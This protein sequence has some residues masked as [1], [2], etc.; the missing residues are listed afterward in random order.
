MLFRSARPETPVNDTGDT[1]KHGD[2]FSGLKKLF[3]RA[4]APET[5]TAAASETQVTPAST[6]TSPTASENTAEDKALATT[7]VPTPEPVVAPTTTATAP[8]ASQNSPAP[9][10]ERAPASPSIREMTADFHKIMGDNQGRKNGENESGDVI[11]HAEGTAPATQHLTDHPEE[12]PVPRA[13]SQPDT[14]PPVGKSPAEPQPTAKSESAATNPVPRTTETSATSDTTDKPGRLRGFFGK[15][16]G[17]KQNDTST[18]PTLSTP[19]QEN[20]VTAAPATVATDHVQEQKQAAAEESRQA[21]EPVTATEKPV[22]VARAEPE[23]QNP[24]LAETAAKKLQATPLETLTAR[25]VEGDAEAQYQ[26]GKT[27]YLGDQGTPDYGQAFIWYRRAALQGHAEAQYNLGTMYL[28]GE[29]IA[30]S[31]TEAKDWYARAADQGHEA[32]RHN[33]ENL[34]QIT[35]KQETPAP[36]TEVAAVE[37]KAE[38]KKG[39]VLGYLGKFFK[40]DDEKEAANVKTKGNSGETAAAASPVAAA[41]SAPAANTQPVNLAP[42]QNEYERGLAYS[43]GKGVPQDYNSAFKL[44]QSAA[45]QNYA[46]AQYQLGNAYMSGL[47]T[48]NNPEAAADWYEKAARQGYTLA[49]RTLGSMYMHGDG[50]KQNKPLALAWYSILAREGNVLDIQRRDTLQGELNAADMQESEKLKQELS[51]SLPPAQAAN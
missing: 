33:L 26:L 42:G 22:V 44:F 24:P 7:E 29:G 11:A 16:F 3:T 17:K 5:K 41:S 8:A 12:T 25:A 51:A 48:E 47:G 37:P 21:Q 30:Q 6:E 45:Q 34:Q 4:P 39:G 49:Q 14:N 23:T 10:P 32:A 31:D 27:Y 38:K 13:V 46:A 9:A 43:E 28:M 20:A 36:T 2:L 18:T 15:L 35:P 40:S 50:V 1:Q 19:V